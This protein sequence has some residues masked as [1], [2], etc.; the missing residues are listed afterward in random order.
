MIKTTQVWERGRER[1]EGRKE[2]E[3]A[4]F[5]LSVWDR[6]VRSQK[7]CF[8]SQSIAILELYTHQQVDSVLRL[9]PSCNRD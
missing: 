7:S 1:R 6:A 8:C 2:K 5:Y 9:F 4:L 3:R